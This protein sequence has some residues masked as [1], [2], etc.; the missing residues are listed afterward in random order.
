M[1]MRNEIFV[2]FTESAF[3]HGIR[4]EQITFVLSRY[5]FDDMFS[6]FPEKHLLIGFDKNGILLEILYRMEENDTK[7]IVFHAMKC[8]KSYIS[9]LKS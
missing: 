3:K 7:M 2:E 1:V 8:R 6:I 9:L 5:L 4:K